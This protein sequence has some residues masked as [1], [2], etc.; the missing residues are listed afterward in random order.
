VPL[1]CCTGRRGNEGFGPV[2]SELR[3]VGLG[4][5]DGRAVLFVGTREDSAGDEAEM[6]RWTLACGGTC[7][8][9]FVKS[10]SGCCVGSVRA[11]TIP[12]LGTTGFR[13]TFIACGG[14]LEGF[15]YPGLGIGGCVVV[16]ECDGICDLNA[17][18]C[19]GISSVYRPYPSAV[20]LTGF[21]GES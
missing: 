4:G 13:A 5:A 6:G 3:W 20:L 1:S 17:L 16:V 7:E 21:G 15:G 18:A 11:C 8:R 10:I 14:T 9:G 2:D 19:V 12:G